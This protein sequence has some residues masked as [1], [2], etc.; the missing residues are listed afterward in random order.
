MDRDISYER[1]VVTTLGTLTDLTQ[2]CVGGGALDE[3]AK[4][5]GDPFT[6]VSPAFGDPGFCH[7]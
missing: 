6:N 2:A 7:Q 1:P 4:G 5:A 3:T